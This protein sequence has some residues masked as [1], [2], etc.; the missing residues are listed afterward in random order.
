ML[1]NAIEAPGG[2]HPCRAAGN[3]SAA[4][5]AVAV[6]VAVLA[7]VVAGPEQGQAPIPGRPPTTGHGPSIVGNHTAN[8]NDEQ[9]ANA[10]RKPVRADAPGLAI[11]LLQSINVDLNSLKS[12]RTRRGFP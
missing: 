10:T 4:R 1:M 6:V 2:H 12:R 11:H 5:S 8:S 7:D 9:S 3:T